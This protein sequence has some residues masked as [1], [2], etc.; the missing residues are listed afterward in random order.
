M[1][2]AGPGLPCNISTMG[3]PH[4]FFGQ[5]PTFFSLYMFATDALTTIMIFTHAC[6]ARLLLPIFGKRMEI[7]ARTGWFT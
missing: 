1:P 3:L 4:P 5:A 6:A 7:P 2:A